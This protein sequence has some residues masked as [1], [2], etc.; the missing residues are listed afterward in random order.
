MTSVLTAGR[1][2]R[3]KHANSVSSPPAALSREGISQALIPINLPT[4]DSSA[5]FPSLPTLSSKTNL[6]KLQM[7]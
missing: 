1:G 7:I 2:L 3:V 5:T 6:T 4:Y